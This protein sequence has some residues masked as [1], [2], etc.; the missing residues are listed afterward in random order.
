MSLY[1][2]SAKAGGKS[3]LAYGFGNFIKRMTSQNNRSTEDG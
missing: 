1:F 3:K 2:L